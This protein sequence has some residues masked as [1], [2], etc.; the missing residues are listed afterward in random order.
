MAEAWVASGGGARVLYVE[1][2]YGRLAS[3]P[4]LRDVARGL[5]AL[6]IPKLPLLPRTWPD[7]VR[8]ANLAIGRRLVL[9]ALARLGLDRPIAVYYGWYWAEWMRRLGE[10]V[11]V[12]ECIDEHRG[13]PHLAGRRRRIDYVWRH[14]RAM[15]ARTDVYAAL[16]PKLLEER[17]PLVRGP[18]IVL[19]NAIDLGPYDAG[20]GTPEPAALAGLARPRALFLGVLKGTIDVAGIARLAT[21]RPDAGFVLVGI[22][23]EGFELPPHPPNVPRLRPP[24]APEIPAIKAHGAVGRRP[25]RPRAI[26]EAFFP[27]KILEYLAGGLAVAGNRVP[28][29]EAWPAEFGTAVSIEPDLS[30]AFD[31]A[32]GESRA[33]GRDE[34]R[35]L[36]AGRSW[37]ARAR[38]LLETVLA[39]E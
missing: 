34:R 37:A 35:A 16:T 2:E 1:V 33:R 12:Y 21:S 19:P 10:R 7:A 13:Y 38:S 14:E 36:L 3:P 26:T 6:P 30:A 27:I 28:G 20:P 31:R 29:A 8:R 11:A 25:V 9:R 24:P 22:R 18:N 39:A 4:G 32:L 15:L 17:A 5:H 23:Q